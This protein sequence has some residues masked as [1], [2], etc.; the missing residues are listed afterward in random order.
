VL[1]L[2]HG[3]LRSDDAVL[4]SLARGQTETGRVW[5]NVRGSSYRGKDPPAAQFFPLRDRTREHPER[6][7]ATYAPILQP[8]AFDGYERLYHP[9]HKPV[10]IV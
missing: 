7:L 9:D 1:R 5:V 2:V 6:R 8:D 3:R 10:P 4:P